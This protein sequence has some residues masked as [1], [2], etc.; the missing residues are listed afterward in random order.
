MKH[1]LAS[2]RDGKDTYEIEHRIVRK[3]TGEIRFVHE[4]CE[5]FRDSKGDIVRSVG[6]VHDITDRI[7]TEEKTKRILE[8][9]GESYVE[10]DNEWR[11]VDVNTKTEKL[12]GI[13]KDK[14]VNKVVWELFPQLIGTKQYKELHRAKKENIPVKFE[15]QSLL[16]KNWYEINAYPH[17]EGLSV[18]SNNINERKTK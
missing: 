6:M 15:T 9:I 14:L 2:I 12:I 11:Y 16:S 8:S 18:Y 1:T 17:P 10:Y 7:K 13:D 3:Y 5:H 4:K